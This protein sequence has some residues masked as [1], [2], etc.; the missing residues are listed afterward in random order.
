MSAQPQFIF[1]RKEWM[2]S[3]QELHKQWGGQFDSGGDIVTNMGGVG[4]VISKYATLSANIREH[5]VYLDAIMSDSAAYAKIYIYGKWNTQLILTLE[6]IHDRFLKLLGLEYEITMPSNEA[7]IVLFNKKYLIKGEPKEFVSDFF[8]DYKNQEVIGNLGD[9]WILDIKDN[10]TKLTYEFTSAE[11]I[12]S[13]LL[14]ERINYLIDLLQ[15]L[16]QKEST[17]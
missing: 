13:E 1:F 10:L 7:N 3:L 11:E 4:S 2:A 8:S 15:A 6:D 9:F 14:S 17:R 5:K 12:K 16:E